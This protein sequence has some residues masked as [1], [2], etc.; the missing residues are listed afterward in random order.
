VI[1]L[2][3]GSLRFV[4][5]DGIDGL[6]FDEQ[7][8][9]NVNFHALSHCMKTVDFIVEIPNAYLFVEV[10]NPP[11]GTEYDAPD[12]YE[13]LLKGLVTKFRDSFLYRWAEKKITKPIYYFCLVDVDS[14][15]TLKITNDLKRKLPEKGPKNRWKQPLVSSCAVSNIKDWNA[16]FP[17]RQIVSIPAIP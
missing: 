15:L 8:A 7:D 11:L 13:K 1:A 17:N 3:E 12:A 10:K 2:E 5:T 4:F 9:T 14:A 6:K 16:A